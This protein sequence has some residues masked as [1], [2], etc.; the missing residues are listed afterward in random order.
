MAESPGPPWLAL[1]FKMYETLD[2][3]VPNGQRPWGRNQM[4]VGYGV[5]PRGNSGPLVCAMPNPCPQKPLRSVSIRGLQKS[6]LLVA[7]LTLYSGSDNPL[8]H[9]P[10]RTYRLRVPGKQAEVTEAAVDMGAI[11]PSAKGLMV[12]VRR[13]DSEASIRWSRR[14]AG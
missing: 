13:R 9:L 14:K 7:G 2:P 4:G 12:P 5:V 11:D 1:G 6:P 3:T 8:R 10:R